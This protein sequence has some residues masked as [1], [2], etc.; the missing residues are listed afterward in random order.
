VWFFSRVWGQSIAVA[1]AP[2][3]ALLS[4]ALLSNALLSNAL[5]SNALLLT[6]AC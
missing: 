2:V 5:L 6:R 4:N 3:D 1:L